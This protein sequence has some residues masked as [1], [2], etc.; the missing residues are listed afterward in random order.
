MNEALVSCLMVTRDRPDLVARSVAC[1]SRQQHAARELVIVDDGDVDLLP[2]LRPF[3]RQG[4]R[5]RYHR[6][7]ARPGV[8]LGDLR[9]EAI[10][11]ARGEWCLQW[12][13][14]EWYHADRIGAQWRARQ[15]AGRAAVAVVL[16][17][18]LMVVDSP[19]H[20]FLAYRADAGFATPGTVLHRRDAARYPSLARGEDSAFLRDLR[21][22]GRVAV[23]GREASHLFV[24]VFH[25]ANTW[26]EE[27]F[28]RRLHR[29]PVDWPSYAAA[30]WWHRDLTRHRAF[31]LDDRECAAV[32]ALRARPAQPY[33]PIEADA[34][35][36]SAP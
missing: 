30:R 5:I 10:D 32:D 15:Q 31:R 36:R 22:A 6:L 1:F 13:D 21:R 17:W 28:L 3:L 19:R 24:R 11:R 8:L 23:L 12:D 29:R 7:P 16:R 34:T 26:D 2:V 4:E 35:V 9:N 18:T 20:G 27:H 14:D 33:A 25:G